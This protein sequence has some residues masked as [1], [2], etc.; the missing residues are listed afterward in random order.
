M[1]RSPACYGSLPRSS[2]IELIDHVIVGDVKADP[3]K[4]AHYSFREPGL[5]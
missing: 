4:V 1:F 3:Q 5:L 2:T